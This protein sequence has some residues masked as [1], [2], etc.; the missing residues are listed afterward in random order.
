MDRQPENGPAGVTHDH[1]SDIDQP[2][3]QL[4]DPQPPP[5]AIQM[6]ILEDLNQVVGQ[7]LELKEHGIG[8]EIFREDMV[9]GIAFLELP[10]DILRFA[11]LAVEANHLMRRPVGVG[12]V[13]A[14]AVLEL[15][16]QSPLVI[17]FGHHDQP[18]GCSFFLRTNKMEAFPDL[19]IDLATPESLP[20]L[21]P[22]DYLED[23]L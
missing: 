20:V 17:S 13:E 7:K 2:V 9:E 21:Y 16:E 5:R 10:D 11:P 8:Q 19:L 12:E 18:V 22:L 3:A 1:T 15:R 6:G 23:S 14:I 4:F